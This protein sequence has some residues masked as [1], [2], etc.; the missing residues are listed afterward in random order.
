MKED[1]KYICIPKTST[2]LVLKSGAGLGFPYSASSEYDG[3]YFRADRASLEVKNSPND[4]TNGLAWCAYS[5]TAIGQWIQM[6]FPSP[7]LV[8]SL[9]T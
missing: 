9:V 2:D 3:I 7:K 1:D 4:P 6:S 5:N 8:V